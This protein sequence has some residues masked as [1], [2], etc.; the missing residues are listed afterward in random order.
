MW[1]LSGNREGARIA[2]SVDVSAEINLNHRSHHKYS[3]VT[4][5]VATDSAK[6]TLSGTPFDERT[7]ATLGSVP[8]LLSCKLSVM[9]V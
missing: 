7:E 3:F 9:R 6:A 1:F 4:I 8:V 2:Q 5:K